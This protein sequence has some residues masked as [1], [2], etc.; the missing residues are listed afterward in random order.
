MPVFG[1]TYISVSEC[2][3]YFSYPKAK[4][5]DLS[6]YLVTNGD[7]SEVEYDGVYATDLF[8]THECEEDSALEL[9]NMRRE[10]V[11]N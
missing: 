11:P 3:F 10:P 8:S 9:V 4:G 6:S 2:R 7:F 5:F 1:R